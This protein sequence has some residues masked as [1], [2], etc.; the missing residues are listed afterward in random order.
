MTSNI[1][2][3]YKA[4]FE[5][6]GLQKRQRIWKTLCAS[7]FNQI[8]R[9]KKTA[10]RHRYRPIKVG[11]RFEDTQRQKGWFKGAFYDLQIRSDC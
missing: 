8:A 11:F 5:D 9:R 4:R 3:I 10:S 7:F 2:A 1:Q 6:T